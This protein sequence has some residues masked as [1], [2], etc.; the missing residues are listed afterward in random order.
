[1]VMACISTASYSVFINGKVCGNNVP[2]RGVCQRCPL[3]LYLFLL[4]VE[5]LSSL[6]LKADGEEVLKGI[7]ASCLSSRVNHLLFA[8]DCLIFVRLLLRMPNRCLI[9]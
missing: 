8:D 7:R 5:R 4:C 6:L 3:S 9:F 1:M 2:T